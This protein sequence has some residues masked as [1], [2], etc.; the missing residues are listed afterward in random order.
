MC[1]CWKKGQTSNNVA[2]PLYCCSSLARRVLGDSYLKKAEW[3]E[4]GR[5]EG[6]KEKKKGD[7]RDHMLTNK[8]DENLFREK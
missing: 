1:W 4:G 8:K 5:K 3:R 2:Q 7:R 6:R